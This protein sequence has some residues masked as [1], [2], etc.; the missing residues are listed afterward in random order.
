MWTL[1]HCKS[2]IYKTIEAYAVYKHEMAEVGFVSFSFIFANLGVFLGVEKASKICHT[3]QWRHNESDG[4]S[5]HQ[6]CDG[7]PN[8]LFRRRSKKTS[9]LRVTSI[10]EG[11]CHEHQFKYIDWLQV[12]L[13]CCCFRQTR[14]L[15]GNCKTNNISTKRSLVP[16]FQ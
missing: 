16:D 13:K 3:L 11:G 15:L 10:C 5:N 2:R 1:L 14:K 8:R 4:V 9:K 6:S 12:T 7:L